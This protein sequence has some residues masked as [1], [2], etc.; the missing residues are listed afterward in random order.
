MKPTQQPLSKG[1]EEARQQLPTIL[2]AAAAGQSTLITRHGRAVA[3]VVPASALSL[4]KPV[5]LLTL[6]GTAQHL[7]G[8][9]SAGTIDALREKWN[10]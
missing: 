9:D 6:A 1:A 7:W 4:R 8:K 5:S 10:R 2:A 3:A